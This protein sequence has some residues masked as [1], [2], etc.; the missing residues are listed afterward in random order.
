MIDSL[1]ELWFKFLTSNYLIYNTCWEDPEIDRK[2][3]KIDSNSSVFTI[4]SAGDNTFAYLNDNPACVHTT[5]INPY[6]NALFEL[7]RALFLNGKYEQLLELFLTGKSTK[8]QYIFNDIRPL[9]SGESVAFWDQK[10]HWFSPDEGFYN[11]ALTGKFARILRSLLKLKG[12]ERTA[13]ELILEP[14]QKNRSEIFNHNIEPKLWSGLSKYFWK[15]NWMLALAGIPISQSEQMVD[16][17]GHM[18]TCLRNIFVEQS[19]KSNHFW[20]LYI[21]GSYQLDCLPYYLKEENFNL[22]SSQISKITNSVGSVSDFLA[23]TDTKYSHFTLLD[24]Q[25]WLVGANN[26]ELIREWK[27]IFETA[28][29][30]AKVLFRS[31]HKSLGFLPNFVLD[32]INQIPIDSNF[33]KQHDRVG[34]YPSTFLIELDV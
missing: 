17:N 34:T 20:R 8:Y 4:T 19:P 33:L 2:L 18:K 29:P 21:Q 13:S 31:V 3:L 25:D 32:Q 23:Q 22:I 27:Y 6:Q 26:H 15:T 10:I 16:L 30:G 7:K 9:L 12:L 5:D 11:H 1:S 24:H 14:N 28:K